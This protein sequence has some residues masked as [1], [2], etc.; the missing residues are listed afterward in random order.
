[1]F[2]ESLSP[3]ERTAFAV[4]FGIGRGGPCPSPAD[5]ERIRRG[6]GDHIGDKLC[7]HCA[8]PLPPNDPTVPG[9]PPAL[10]PPCKAAGR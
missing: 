2:W 4:G 9:R 7:R 6:V 5:I 10:C 8:R 1:M 3:R